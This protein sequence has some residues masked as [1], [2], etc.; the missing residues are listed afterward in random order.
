M[1]VIDFYAKE[2][3]VL[4]VVESKKV[5]PPRRLLGGCAGF[6]FG[7]FL[8]FQ[9]YGVARA[10]QL[11]TI[12]DYLSGL[13]SG[14]VRSVEIGDGEYGETL[15]VYPKDSKRQAYSV[16]IRSV[17][18]GQTEVMDERKISYCFWNRPIETGLNCRARMYEIGG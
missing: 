14:S 13:P 16:A 17:S 3:L 6:L 1:S 5:F 15:I 7:L 2:L 8:V 10:H 4:N 18:F 11:P 12:T 9:A